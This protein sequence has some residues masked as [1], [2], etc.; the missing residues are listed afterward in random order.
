MRPGQLE[1]VTGDAT[2]PQTDEPAVI[3]HVCNDVGGWGKGFV[4]AISRRWPLPEREYRH[5]YADRATNDF[6]LGAVQFVTVED[7]LWV[8][9]LVGQ[10]GMYRT[11][12]GPPVRYDAIETG[13]VT[14]ADNARVLDAS[15]H[16]PRIGCGLAGGDWA[17]IEPILKRTL[18]AAGIDT[19]VYDLP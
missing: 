9:N 16:M 10:R 7:Q 18:I 19:V 11:K 13:L 4:L 14:V 3:V 2:E 15:V 12:S 5:W 17:E 8:A 6:A 1:Y